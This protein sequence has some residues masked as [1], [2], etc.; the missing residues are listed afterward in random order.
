MT[1]FHCPEV[2]TK[3]SMLRFKALAME[4]VIGP[5]ALEDVNEGFW[6]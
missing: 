3:G 2:R 6:K 1:Y 5:P 4:A